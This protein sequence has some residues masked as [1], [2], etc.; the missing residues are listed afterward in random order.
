MERLEAV[1]PKIQSFQGSLLPHL[2]AYQ[3]L[4]H[5]Q[6]LTIL[7]DQRKQYSPKLI[8]YAHMPKK[9]IFLMPAGA[10]TKSDKMSQRKINWHILSRMV[11]GA[12]TQVCR[13]SGH[14]QERTVPS[15][16]PRKFLAILRTV[17]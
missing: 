5:R 12:G 8:A 10:T 17:S 15:E 6:W 1:I 4:L 11:L 9:P 2:T 13:Y 3:V 7:D 16:L 14:V